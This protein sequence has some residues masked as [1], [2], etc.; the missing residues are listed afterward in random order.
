MIASLRRIAREQAE[1]N[2][3]LL[4]LVE[5]KEYG[6]YASMPERENHFGYA[7]CTLRGTPPTEAIIIPREIEEV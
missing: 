7:L 5:G 1:L 6:M 3:G 4:G 2:Q